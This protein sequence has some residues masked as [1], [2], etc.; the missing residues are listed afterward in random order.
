LTSDAELDL[1]TEVDR[2]IQ[3]GQIRYFQSA[4]YVCDEW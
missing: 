1:A 2:R 3:N 4:V